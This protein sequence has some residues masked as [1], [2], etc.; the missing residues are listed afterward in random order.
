MIKIAFISLSSA[1]LV[2]LTANCTNQATS[3][4]D[5]AVE[6]RTIETEKKTGNILADER[7]EG[8]GR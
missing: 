7:I 8:T 5:T 3:P 6:T 2:F 1:A 4:G